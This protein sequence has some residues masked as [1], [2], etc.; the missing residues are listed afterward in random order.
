MVIS[1]ETIS[2]GANLTEGQKEPKDEIK[3][4]HDLARTARIAIEGHLEDLSENNL[5]ALDAVDALEG[6]VLNRFPEIKSYTAATGKIISPADIH[7][8]ATI[9]REAV[10]NNS[11]E[12]N[13]PAL[14]AINELKQMAL[15]ESSEATEGIG[16]EKAA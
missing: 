13:D 11:L 4:I 16:L 3:R 5:R 2:P 15:E 7:N 9:S 1:G 10:K 8:L 6:L 14:K 12:K